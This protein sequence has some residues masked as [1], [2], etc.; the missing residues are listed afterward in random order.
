MLCC[1]T[2]PGLNLTV[3]QVEFLTFSIP[4]GRVLN[5]DA[6]TLSLAMRIFAPTSNLCAHDGRML[7]AGLCLLHTGFALC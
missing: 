3:S 2:H 4:N 1:R 6:E 5:I 7:A